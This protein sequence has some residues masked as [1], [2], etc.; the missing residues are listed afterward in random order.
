V[1]VRWLLADVLAPPT[2]LETFDFIFD[3]GCYHG[4]RRGNAQGYV[5]TLKRLSRSG[6]NI[7]ILAGNANEE[8]HYGPP[9]VKEE[10]LRSDF[11]S[12]FDF[13]RLDTVHFDSVDPKTNGAIAWSVLLR[14]KAE[15]EP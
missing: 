14:R 1:K 6:T 7:L 11:S 2:D 4:V 8:R 15:E 3:R 10:E 12:A 9:R 5:K 13:V